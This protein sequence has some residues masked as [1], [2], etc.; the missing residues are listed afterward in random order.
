MHSALHSLFNYNYSFF[1]FRKTCEEATFS[2]TLKSLADLLRGR[3]STLLLEIGSTTTNDDVRCTH[4]KA[5][6]EFF[7]ETILLRQETRVLPKTRTNAQLIKKFLERQY[8]RVSEGGTKFTSY[9]IDGKMQNART[10]F[11]FSVWRFIYCY[12]SLEYL[13]SPITWSAHGNGDKELCIYKGRNG[14]TRFYTFVTVSGFQLK[15]GIWDNRRRIF[16]YLNFGG[17]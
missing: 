9:S 1:L 12:I 13:H 5:Q 14:T 2:A 4:N 10:V 17:I 3:A 16:R 8:Q 6:L 11:L 15:I 7:Y